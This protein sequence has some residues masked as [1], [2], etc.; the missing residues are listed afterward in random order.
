[1]IYQN[2]EISNIFLTNEIKFLGIFS[3]FKIN[4]TRNFIEKRKNLHL[5]RERIGQNDHIS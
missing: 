1:M 2:T 5:Y 4:F 3:F